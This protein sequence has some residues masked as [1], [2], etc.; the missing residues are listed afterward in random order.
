VVAYGLTYPFGVFGVIFWLHLFTRIF[1]IDFTKAESDRASQSQA[2][3]I[4]SKTYR[5]TNPALS[6]QSVGQVR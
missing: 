2:E 5:I 4:L 1:K 6:G 3:A